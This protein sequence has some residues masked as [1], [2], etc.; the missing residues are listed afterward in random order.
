M[1]DKNNKR[2]DTDTFRKQPTPKYQKTIF[3]ICIIII[4]VATVILCYFLIAVF[5][6]IQ[7]KI[8][9]MDSHLVE[10]DK[11]LQKTNTS[12]ISLKRSLQNTNKEL[13]QTNERLS[14]LHIDFDHKL[15]DFPVKFK[16]LHKNLEKTARKLDESWLLSL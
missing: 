7:E 1:I 5:V 4:T 12:I 9:D 10:V 16:K 15:E 3:K 13:R 2:E 11:R 6:N 8:T 14:S